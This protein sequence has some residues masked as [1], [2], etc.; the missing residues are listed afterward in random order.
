ML[1]V[2]VDEH[3]LRVVLDDTVKLVEEHPPA[4]HT[5]E[6][7][8]IMRNVLHEMRAERFINGVLSDRPRRLH[9][10]VEDVRVAGDVDAGEPLLLVLP[11]RE[12]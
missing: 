5:F 1:R 7:G 10:V 4:V 6:L 8:T 11:A 12:V 9:Q 2:R 3:T